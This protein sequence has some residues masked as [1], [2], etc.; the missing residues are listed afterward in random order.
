MPLMSRLTPSGR[1][2][3]CGDPIRLYRRSVRM[4]SYSWRAIEAALS[5]S[6]PNLGP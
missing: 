1:I 4:P 6:Q 5:R 2:T 3:W